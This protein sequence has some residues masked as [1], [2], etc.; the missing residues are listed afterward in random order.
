M[1]ILAQSYLLARL[2]AIAYQSARSLSDSLRNTNQAL[3]RFV[4]TQFL[5]L[6]HKKDITEIHLGDQVMQSMTVMFTDIRSFTT[7]SE[8]MTPEENFNFLNSYLKRMTPI[9]NQRGGFV[10][11]YIGDAV[12]ALFPGAPDEALRAAVEMQQEVRVYNSHRAKNGY[13]PINIG[14]GLHTGEIMLGIIGHENRM[15]GTVISDTVNTASRVEGLTR[16]YGAVILVSNDV[17]DKLEQPDEFERRRLGLVRVKG[18]KR[19]FPVYEILNGYTDDLR[20]LFLETRESFHEAVDLAYSE[21][22]EE[23][24]NAF[25]RIQ[26]RNPMDKAAGFYLDRIQSR[27]FAPARM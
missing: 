24:A 18:K 4:P 26:E 6:L 5:R 13:N 15:E 20:A 9:V 3:T 23:A 7:L 10:D 17:L 27:I 21:R 22:Y 14:I 12:M 1:F 25:A 11:K 19:A 16:R 2:F 8:Q